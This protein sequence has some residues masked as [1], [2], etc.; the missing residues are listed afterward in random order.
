MPCIYIH[1]YIWLNEWNCSVLE[2]TKLVQ[3]SEPLLQFWNASLQLAGTLPGVHRPTARKCLD[4]FTVSFSNFMKL[5]LLLK[6][7]SNVWLYYFKLLN[8]SAR[9][10]I[11]H[12]L[13][14]K[15]AILDT[16]VSCTLYAVSLYDNAY[17]LFYAH[18][19]CSCVCVSCA[20]EK[21]ESLVGGCEHVH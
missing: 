7:A 3:F 2:D 9:V 12:Y 5:T 11:S 15:D 6:T 1:I 13:K 19:C 14:H 20:W 16:F 8:F 10:C 18:V 17:A 4:N 21:C